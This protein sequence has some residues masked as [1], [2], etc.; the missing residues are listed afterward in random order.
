MGPSG[1]VYY[2]CFFRPRTGVGS[3]GLGVEPEEN[4]VDDGSVA[5]SPVWVL[6]ERAEGVVPVSGNSEW[7][8]P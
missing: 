3:D 6:R 4:G 5:G 8:R 7:F 1:P 2:P